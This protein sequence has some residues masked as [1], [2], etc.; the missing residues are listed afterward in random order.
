MGRAL[1]VTDFLFF[2]DFFLGLGR[3]ML[4]WDVVIIEGFLLVMDCVGICS[5]LKKKKKKKKKKKPV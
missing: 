2:L 3:R 1:S 4:I 5:L